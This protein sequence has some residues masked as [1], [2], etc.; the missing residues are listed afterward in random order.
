MDGWNWS[1]LGRGRVMTPLKRFKS[2]GQL[3][4]G[5]PP[6]ERADRRS[7]GFSRQLWTRGFRDRARR[8]CQRWAFAPMPKLGFNFVMNP[9]RADCQFL[10]FQS[11][12]HGSQLRYEV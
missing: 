7:I 6:L 1:L 8:V 4:P 2:S 3:R 12:L 10:R 9:C 11:L 5:Y